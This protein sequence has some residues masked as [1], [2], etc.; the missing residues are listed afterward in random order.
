MT[1]A[2]LLRIQRNEAHLTALGQ[3]CRYYYQVGGRWSAKTTEVLLTIL[4]G[5]L[6]YKRL[7]VCIFRKVYDSIRD[8]V[9]ADMVQLINDLGLSDL[10]TCQRS[11]FLIKSNLTESVCLF[12]GAQENERLKGLAGIHWVFLEELNEFTQMDF[13]TIDQ[14]IRGKGY[15]HKVFMAHNPV[16]RCV[17]E[18]YWFEK[19]FTPITLEPGRPYVFDIKS[20]G[21]VAALKTTYQHNAFTPDHVRQR[22]EG[23]RFTNPTLYKLWALGDYTE[24]KGAILTNWDEVS[25]APP[26]VDLI[27]Y[28]LDFGFSSDPAALIAVYGNRQELWL[29]QLI[30]STGLTN[31]DLADRM[32]LKGLT[33]NSRIV[34]DSA[35][36]K[37]IEDLFREGFRGIKGVKKRANYKADMALV[38]QGYTIHIIS[39]SNDLKREVQT[40]SWDEDKTGKLLPVPRDGNDHLI[41]AMIMLMHTYR[42]PRLMKVAGA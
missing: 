35:E 38:L 19:L 17:G 6:E 36:P 1:Q 42:G 24:I 34:A 37:S 23:Y 10:F 2:A 15:K 27:G 4:T 18:P 32:R 41:D 28:G 40:W 7:R 39:G 12:K 26:N 21:K 3:D 20:L 9:Y 22:L 16:P 25:A 11:P 31:R 5:M 29:Q 8:S 33:A 14:G 13:E 30:Y